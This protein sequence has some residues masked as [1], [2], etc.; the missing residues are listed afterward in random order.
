MEISAVVLTRNEEKNIAQCLG[1]LGFGDELVII[2]DYSDDKTRRIAKKLGAK[3]YKRKLEGDFSEQ[4]NFGLEKARGRW[5]L[6]ADADEM[7][8]EKLAS[9]IV[10]VIKSKPE[11]K[12]F[13]FKRRAKFMGRWLRF[14]EIGAVSFLRLGRRGV[15]QWQGRVHEVW[16]IKG[17]KVTLREPLLHKQD[18]SLGEFVKRIDFYSTLRAKELFQKGKQ[19]CFFELIIF[20][21]AK[22]V[23][24]YFLRVAFL[25]GLPGLILTILMSSHSFLVR[26]KLFILWRK[27]A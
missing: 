7:V 19:F 24:N 13:F 5:V 15:G 3:V 12:G 8:T 6:F 9:E 11:V 1:A 23:Q 10:Q 17:K 26:A 27:N 2:D 14:G 20:P 21:I 18:V 22:F 16:K 4:R 25:D